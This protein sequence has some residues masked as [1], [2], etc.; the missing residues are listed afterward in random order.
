VLSAQVVRVVGLLKLELVSRWITNS[1]SLL[2]LSVHC[3]LICLSEIGV[4]LRLLG[5]LTLV[6]GASPPMPAW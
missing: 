4:A 6:S 3:R 2:E 1:V 5:A